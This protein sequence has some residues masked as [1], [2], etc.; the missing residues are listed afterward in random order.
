ML[1]ADAKRSSSLSPSKAREWTMP[2]LVLRRVG[3]LVDGVNKAW[4]GAG[5]G[6]GRGRGSSSSGGLVAT[7]FLFGMAPCRLK[8]SR[9]SSECSDCELPELPELEE[10]GDGTSSRR[11]NLSR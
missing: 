7:V 1:L 8:A 6:R 10:A 11:V 4:T 9:S 5:S 2:G 3:P